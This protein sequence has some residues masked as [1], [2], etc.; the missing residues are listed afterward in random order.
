[1]MVCVKLTATLP[2]LMLVSALPSVC[3]AASGE[4][5]VACGGGAVERRGGGIRDQ[6]RARAAA[7]QGPR[8]QRRCVRAQQQQQRQRISESASMARIM[9]ACRLTFSTKL[10]SGDLCRRSSHMVQAMSEPMKNWAA[11]MVS[12]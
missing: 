4:M 7:G 8:R 6:D 9:H 1:M 5:E 11:V 3:T 2:R 12:G 10:P